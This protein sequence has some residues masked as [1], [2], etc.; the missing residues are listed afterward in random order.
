MKKFNIKHYNWDYQKGYKKAL[1][2]LKEGR[3]CNICYKSML[4]NPVR[5][6]MCDECHS[7]E[8]SSDCLKFDKKL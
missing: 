6:F 3:I 5:N 2:L 4:K 7:S 8:N 1:E